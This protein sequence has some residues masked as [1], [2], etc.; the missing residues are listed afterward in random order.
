MGVGIALLFTISVL[1][2]CLIGYLWGRAD[3]RDSERQ[4]RRQSRG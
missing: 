2:G 4:K 3:G 1:W